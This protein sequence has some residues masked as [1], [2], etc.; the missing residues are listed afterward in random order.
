[1]KP[2]LKLLKKNKLTDDIRDSLSN[3]IKFVLQ[4]D[5]I[6]GNDNVTLLVY[7]K[8]GCDWIWI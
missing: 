6:I 1:M 4:R 7:E 3:M 2:L 5:Y 8:W